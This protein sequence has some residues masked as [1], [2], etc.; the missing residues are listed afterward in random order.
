M[1]FK[2][3]VKSKTWLGALISFVIMGVSNLF[4]AQQQSRDGDKLLES[5]VPANVQL[6]TPSHE[7]KVVSY[8]IRWRSGHELEQIIR[9]L[10]GTKDS[11]APVIIALQE[12]DRAKLR[13]GK[14]DHAKAIADSLG[15]YYVWTAPSSPTV[16]KKQAEEETGVVLLSYFPLTEIRRIALPHAGPGGRGR[17]AL[18]A[19]ITIDKMNLRVYSVHSE[20][21]I[22]IAQ[23][24]DQLRAVLADLAKF[25]AAM[26]AIVMGDFNSW[27]IPT[28]D[29]IRK[30]F[31][32]AGFTTPFPD[33]ETTFSRSAVLFDLKLK[34]D[35]VWLRGLT[36]P[37][38]GIDR[39]L[40]I[41]DHFPLWSVVK[42]S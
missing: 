4:F 37:T 40:T 41:S 31:T 34:L 32:N 21:R 11:T 10:K 26:P 9:W 1:S 39:S 15:M 18:G 14:I 22:P 42:I 27:E 2:Q 36:A 38:Y 35:W 20:T 13:S 6:R 24:M 12:V 17:V 23:K 7:I 28:V 30:L 3:L 16:N 19:T 25:P 5:G 29:G 8:N 33:D